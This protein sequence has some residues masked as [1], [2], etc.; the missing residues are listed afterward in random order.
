[1]VRGLLFLQK[2]ALCFLGTCVS[3]ALVRVE[4]QEAQVS[5]RGLVR[6]SGHD[7]THHT[8]G[9]PD[10]GD[11]FGMGHSCHKIIVYLDA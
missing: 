9:S 10:G 1:M 11:C 8:F 6:G 2:E 3:I 5:A 7:Q 4:R